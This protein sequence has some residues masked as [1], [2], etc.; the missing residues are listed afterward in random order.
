MNKGDDKLNNF[1]DNLKFLRTSKNVKQ[2]DVAISINLTQDGYAKYER[3]QREPD[4]DTLVLLAD[5]FDV[6]LDELI[7]RKA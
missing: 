4:L 3:G 2:K 6:S 1:S 7:K 5:Y